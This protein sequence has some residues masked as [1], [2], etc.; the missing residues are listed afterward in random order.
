MKGG[1][2]GFS[3]D[4]YGS[5]RKDEDDKV[6]KS[7]KDDKEEAKKSSSKNDLEFNNRER[8]KRS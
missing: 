5:S 7:S 8:K 1:G 3:L 6:K 2:N 4:L